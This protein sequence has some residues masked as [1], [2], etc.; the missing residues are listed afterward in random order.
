MGQRR[1][2]SQL[3]NEGWQ[4]NEWSRRADRSRD[5]VTMARGRSFIHVRPTTLGKSRPVNLV[6]RGT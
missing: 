5:H 1:N 6:D 2:R 3:Y 4:T